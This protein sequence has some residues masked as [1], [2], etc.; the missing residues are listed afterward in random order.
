MKL[1]TTFID[2][3]AE[4]VTLNLTAAPL[5]L[6]VVRSP[7]GTWDALDQP[8]DEPKPREQI[9]CYHRLTATPSVACLDGS[10]GRGRWGMRLVSADYGIYPDPPA[11]SVMRSNEDWHQWTTDHERAVIQRFRDTD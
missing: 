3:P 2:G 6:R 5:L 7:G 10:N 8:S 4:G 1:G 11:L 9:L